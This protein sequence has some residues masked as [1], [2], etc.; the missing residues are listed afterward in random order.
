MLYC[1]NYIIILFSGKMNFAMLFSRLCFPF[2]SLCLLINQI[3]SLK[4]VATN[5]LPR[6]QNTT[7]QIHFIKGR[8]SKTYGLKGVEDAGGRGA[9]HFRIPK[10]CQITY[11]FLFIFFINIFINIIVVI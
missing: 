6:I 11:V 7:L 5:E 2:L 1:Q 3:R 10:E 9:N 8:L 4:V